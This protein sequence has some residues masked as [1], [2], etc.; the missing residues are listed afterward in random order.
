MI[1][2]TELLAPGMTLPF[3]FQVS[4]DPWMNALEITAMLVT[5]IVLVRCILFS[6]QVFIAFSDFA[7]ANKVVMGFALVRTASGTDSETSV[8]P[9]SAESR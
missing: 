5:N 6:E 4:P 7:S 1:F 2:R 9:A 8:E 3:F